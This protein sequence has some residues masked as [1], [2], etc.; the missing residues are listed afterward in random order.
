MWCGE[1]ARAQPYG[2]L[3]G[4]GSWPAVL[5]LLSNGHSVA[6]TTTA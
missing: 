5:V 4:G 2:Q 6:L 3:G 1:P